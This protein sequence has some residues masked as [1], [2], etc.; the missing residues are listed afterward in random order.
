MHI[1]ADLQRLK[2]KVARIKYSRNPNELGGRGKARV[3]L[4]K[5][6]LE[7]WEK[8]FGFKC[9]IQIT[10]IDENL[11]AINAMIDTIK[12]RDAIKTA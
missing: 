8:Y 11:L 6:T 9:S 12:K 1:P 5:E 3:T 7:L 4:K 10:N 2:E